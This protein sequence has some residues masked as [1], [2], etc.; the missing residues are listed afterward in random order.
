VIGLALGCEATG[1]FGALR[2]WSLSHG[3][4]GLGA[5]GLA[6]SYFAGVAEAALVSSSMKANPTVLQRDDLIEILKA[7]L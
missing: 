4:P 5:M 7:A 2:D 1:A 3:L 6:Q